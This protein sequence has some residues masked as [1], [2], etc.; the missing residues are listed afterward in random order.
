MEIRHE[1]QILI[2]LERLATAAQSD[3]LASL[4]SPQDQL[5]SNVPLSASLDMFTDRL[6][7]HQAMSDLGDLSA[8]TG[9]NSKAVQDLDDVQLFWQNVVDPLYVSLV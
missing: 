9:T 1:L 3:L 4:V 6:A 5:P 8:S 2:L 7:I